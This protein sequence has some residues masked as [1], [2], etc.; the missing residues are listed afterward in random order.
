MNASIKIK[1]VTRYL[2]DW[3]PLP[4]QESYD[5]SGLLTGDFSADVNGVMVTL[6]C[7]EH[8]VDE[9]IENNCNLIVAHHP[10]L[11][12]GVKRLTGSNYV[13]RTLMKRVMNADH[14]HLDE[15][16]GR[17]LDR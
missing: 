3:A 11:F 8:V 16:R 1:D 2:E 4:Y 14:R 5:N 17:A 7:T 6:D 10:I 9:A 13:E 12:K 15:V